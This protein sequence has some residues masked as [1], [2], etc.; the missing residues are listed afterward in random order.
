MQD[1]LT[2]LRLKQLYFL[3]EAVARK[4]IPVPQSKNYFQIIET[5][6]A[7]LNSFKLQPSQ[8]HTE[9]LI[10]FVYHSDFM[11]HFMD[12]ALD[13]LTRLAEG[14]LPSEFELKIQELEEQSKE[15]FRKLRNLPKTMKHDLV[16]AYVMKH[17]EEPITDQ[18]FSN[19]ENGFRLKWKYANVQKL[20]DEN[21]K[22]D[23]SQYLTSIDST[24][25]RAKME[26]VV[27]LMLRYLQKIRLWGYPME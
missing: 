12:N 17:S 8:Q 25:D 21:F 19:I 9:L 10:R 11:D 2:Q 22:N 24:I 1:I 26:R 4:D 27:D 6:H 18:E 7:I 14:A 15:R 20:G 3:L 5:S 16:K 23:V 13:F